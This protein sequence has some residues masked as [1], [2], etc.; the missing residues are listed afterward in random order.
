M[1]NLWSFNRSIDARIRAS[2]KDLPVLLKIMKRTKQMLNC[3]SNSFSLSKVAILVKFD[4]K[5]M[6]LK[7]P[8]KKSYNISI[9]KWILDIY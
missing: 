8:F 2:D 3:L 6:L 4:Q 1:N 5:E 9:L 7:I